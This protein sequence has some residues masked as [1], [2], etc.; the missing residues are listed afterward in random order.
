[1]KKILLPLFAAVALCQSA[2]AEYTMYLYDRDLGNFNRVSEN[3]KYAVGCD[4]YDYTGSFIVDILNPAEMIEIEGGELYDI[5]NDG[6]AVGAEYEVV[7]G[8]YYSRAAIYVNDEWVRL[9]ESPDCVGQSLAR[10]VSPDGKRIGGMMF[11]TAEDSEIGK[12]Y[13]PCVW[14]LN[15]SS[16]KYELTTYNTIE[17]PDNMGFYTYDMSD[18]GTIITGL[19]N[20]YAGSQVP[21]IVKNGELKLWNKLEVKLWPFEYKD[22]TYYYDTGFVDDI[23]EGAQA[24]YWFSGCL[25]SIKGRYAF[26]HRSV[27]TN[28]DV[29]TGTGTVTHYRSIYDTETD[30]FTDVKTGEFFSCGYDNTKA[31]YT[32]NNTA[33]IMNGDENVAVNEY[34]EVGDEE[35]IAAVYDFD[36]EASVLA[37]SYL[38]LNMSISSYCEAPALIVADK[39]PSAVNVVRVEK[40]GDNTIHDLQGRRIAND[41]ALAPGIYIKNGEKFIVR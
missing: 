28:V 19:V 23:E 20:T 29:E 39:G 8:S 25:N 6:M 37:C 18:D 32:K 16:N 27:A 3:G 22:K 5:T 12:K 35:T 40:Q 26:G 1:M 11:C 34:Y 13:Y 38:W 21:A 9:P 31:F 24:S 15:E 30:T 17:L 36:S 10:A 33:Y 7:S 2:S 41:K 14:T 4:Q